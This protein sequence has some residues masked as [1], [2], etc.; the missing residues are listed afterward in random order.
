MFV[1][2]IVCVENLL[3]YMTFR[4]DCIGRFAAF[5]DMLTYLSRESLT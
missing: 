3:I 4:T 2:M 1:E 5:K